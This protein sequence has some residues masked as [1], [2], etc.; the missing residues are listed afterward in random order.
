[1]ISLQSHGYHWIYTRYPGQIPRPYEETRTRCPLH[2][3]A[4]DLVVSRLLSL[5]L[6]RLKALQEQGLNVEQHVGVDGGCA[7]IVVSK[8]L[9]ANGT[10][11]T[12]VVVG[13]TDFSNMASEKGV[14]SW[15]EAT[16]ADMFVSEDVR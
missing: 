9:W 13:A 2:D 14:T 1:M 16:M 6:R 5:D 4:R 8:W 12:N 10:E 15:G 7:A 3:N 11:T